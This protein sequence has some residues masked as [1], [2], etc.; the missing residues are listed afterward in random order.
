[1]PPRSGLGYDGAALALYCAVQDGAI[2]GDYTWEQI[3]DQS[4]LGEAANR[5]LSIKTEK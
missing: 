5:K 2:E 3:L 4:S 1:M